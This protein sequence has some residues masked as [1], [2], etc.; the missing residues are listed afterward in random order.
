MEEK[1]FWIGILVGIH[2]FL[3]KHFC[4]KGKF[5]SGK[6]TRAWH[7]VF[8]ALISFAGMLLLMVSLDNRKGDVVSTMLFSARQL[9]YGLA[10]AL[11][12]GVFA[13]FRPRGLKAGAGPAD[14]PAAITEDLEWSETVFSAVVLASVVM[15]LFVQAF[16]IPSGSMRS[17]FLEGDHLFVNKF[18]YGLRIPY[19]HKKIFQ[20]GKIKRG[21]IVVFLFPSFDPE[22]DQCGG[23]QF[24]KD[25]IKRVIGLPGEIVEL[26]NGVV[27]VNGTKLP[28]EPYT[29]YVDGMR[30]P[31]AAGGRISPAEYQVF[32][33]NRT[34]AK[35]VSELV[36]D[37]FGPVIVPPGHYL[38]MGDNRDRSCDSRYWGP[39][40]A[41]LIKGKAWFTYWP[42][43]RIG[44]PR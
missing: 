36:R 12:G 6:F 34:L 9:W 13:W 43:S 44:L 37:N 31:R 17:T 40:P 7:A 22:E 33:E 1:L 25:F 23:K 35:M 2:L 5:G 4:D 27:F 28:D 21:D 15:Y 20:F 26:K 24:G 8:I 11:A 19:T 42:P 3:T 32:W 41:Y 39:V 38:V 18:I 10:A 14:R 29:Q 16:K 30:Y